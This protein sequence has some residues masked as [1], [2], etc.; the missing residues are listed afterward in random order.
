[1]N[2]NPLEAILN[3]FNRFTL[4]QKILIIG[5]VAATVVLLG[6]LMF[7]LNEPNFSPLY[8]N[9]A[10]D[11]A[12]KVVNYLNTEKIPY[13]I[14]NNGKTIEVPKEKVYEARMALAGKGIPSSGIVGYEIFD[15]NT[16]GMSEFMQKLNYKRA[17]EGY[18]LLYRSDRFLKMKKKSLPLQ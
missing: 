16:M 1:M 9:L 6:I 11:D 17:L 13:K 8:S 2:K 15:K 3:L 4:Q 12:S 14:D 10:E 18:S 7:F 5:S